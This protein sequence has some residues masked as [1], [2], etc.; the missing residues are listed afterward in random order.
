MYLV[1]V[2]RRH[3][4]LE[5]LHTAGFF[6]KQLYGDILCSTN[7]CTSNEWIKLYTWCNTAQAL[8]QSH[9]HILFK[10]SAQRL[11]ASL[12]T[13]EAGW[14][15]ERRKIT[16][17]WVEGLVR[18]NL[19]S[20]RELISPWAHWARGFWLFSE[21]SRFTPCRKEAAED[22][23]SKANI[24]VSALLAT[25]DAWTANTLQVFPHGNTPK[26]PN[27]QWIKVTL[28]HVCLNVLEP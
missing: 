18:H 19:E 7:E 8:K 17:S 11:G 24:D 2:F 9:A 16:S 26:S 1:H 10:R 15:V 12:D 6:L 27:G 23:N 20:I 25:A 21:Q 4:N 22:S 28:C 5:V 13:W 14:C 3:S